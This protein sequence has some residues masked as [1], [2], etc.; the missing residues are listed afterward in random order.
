MS[1]IEET[2]DQQLVKYRQGNFNVLMPT[3]EILEVNEFW[4][5]KLEVVQLSIDA[6]DAYPQELAWNPAKCN[7]WGLSKNG[8]L[9]LMQCAGVI[10]D[11]VHS[12]R[13]DNGSDKSYCSFQVVGALKKA[14]GSF[15]PMIG[16]YEL[17]L[18]VIEEEI[19]E[20]KWAQ[21]EKMDRK[22]GD[23]APPWAQLKGEERQQAMEDWVESK[24]R[25]E[26]LRKR[27]FK[28]GLAE[29]G[30]LLR[31]IR[32][33]LTIKGTYARDE[34]SQPFVVPKIVFQPNMQD[35]LVRAALLNQSL[36]ALGSVYGAVPQIESALQLPAHVD[37]EPEDIQEVVTD[38]RMIEQTA[39]QTAE[40]AKEVKETREPAKEPAKEVKEEPLPFSVNEPAKPQVPQIN[41]M[42]DYEKLEAAGDV[43]VLLAAMEDLRVRNPNGRATIQV[44]QPMK[45]WK[46]SWR[47][48]F[49]RK[50]LEPN[51][52]AA[53]LVAK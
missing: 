1:K 52:A 11:P 16:N 5:P 47:E 25:S 27:K 17:D 3:R 44:Q 8:L 28:V 48:A 33:I 31:M 4:R 50:M 23:D 46:K 12:K 9:R 39:G 34:L 37:S 10:I 6:G 22:S 19:R 40:Q 53:Q 51:P 45:E 38:R 30:A 49:C 26:V 13:T 7:K 41:S 42:A 15:F 32:A 43:G 18:E 21:A 2:L 14:D 29:T 35:P 36:K 20:Q 24:I